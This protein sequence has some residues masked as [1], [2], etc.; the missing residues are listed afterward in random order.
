MKTPVRPPRQGQR[1]ARRAWPIHSWRPCSPATARPRCTRRYHQH[2][3]RTQEH[4]RP[5][6]RATGQAVPANGPARRYRRRLA[7]TPSPALGAYAQP[8]T[9]T[10]RRTSPATGSDSRPTRRQDRRAYTGTH[11]SLTGPLILG[12]T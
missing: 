1:A 2:A 11:A 12:R 4:L 9:V 10:P 7:Q 5:R 6:P 8:Q 3:A